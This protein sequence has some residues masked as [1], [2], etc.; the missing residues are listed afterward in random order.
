MNFLEVFKDRFKF[1][2]CDITIH[3]VPN[4][5]HA[6]KRFK[7]YD[8]LTRG[9]CYAVKTGG[10][11]NITVL[12]F[13]SLDSYIQFCK[14]VPDFESYFTVKTRRGFHVYFEYNKDVKSGNNVLTFVDVRND[15]CR[16]R[17]GMFY[18][19]VNCP[20]SSYTINGERFT[21]EFLGGEIKPIPEYF[22]TRLANRHNEVPMFS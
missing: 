18:P 5:T 7:F 14:N 8:D 20:P 2:S 17:G 22:F 15:P 21:Y 11:S 3:I 12:D 13:D 1:C 10:I 16:L 19:N 4:T 9:D 6:I